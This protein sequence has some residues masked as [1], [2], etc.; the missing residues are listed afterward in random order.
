M[1]KG[2]GEFN[3]MMPPLGACHIWNYQSWHSFLLLVGGNKC[4]FISSTPLSFWHLP[5]VVGYL[6]LRVKV[7]IVNIRY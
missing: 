3:K 4:F 7:S 6:L 2:R 5:R 1:P